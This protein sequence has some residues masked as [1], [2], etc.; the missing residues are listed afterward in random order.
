MTTLQESKEALEHKLMLNMMS[1]IEN[2]PEISQ[3][4]LSSRLG[5]AIGLVNT[6]VKRCLYKGWIKV[7]QIPTRRYAYYLTPIGFL[8][9]TRLTAEYLTSSFGFFR[10][11]RQEFIQFYEFAQKRN[12]DHLVM[13]GLGDLADI[14]SQVAK[15]HSFKIEQRDGKD[16]SDLQKFD[17]ALITDLKTPQIT[18]ECLLDHIPEEKIFIP[19]LLHVSRNI[20]LRECI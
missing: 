5:V 7:Q 9:K 8:E 15:N 17:A 10:E 1:C 3:R 19:A 14:A 4:A 13:I 12:W 18:F 11:A 6:Y 2:E 20:K 16:F